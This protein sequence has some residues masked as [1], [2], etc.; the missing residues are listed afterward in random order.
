MLRQEPT[1]AETVAR[2]AGGL[3]LIAVV[4]GFAVGGGDEDEDAS[5]ASSST[6]STSASATATPSYHYTPAPAPSSTPSAARTYPPP[7]DSAD[8]RPG[9]AAG[10]P[11]AVERVIDGD[12]FVMA[13]GER[14]RV[15]GIDSCEAGSRGGDSATVAAETLLDGKSVTLRQEGSADRDGFGRLLRY[16]QL[17][18]GRD[19]GSVMIVSSHTSVYEGGDASAGYM[20]DLRARDSGRA[21]G[22]S[23]TTS[24]RPAPPPAPAPRTTSAPTADAPSGGAYY[25]NCDAAEAAG[26]APMLRG[27]PGYRGPLDRDDD[28]IACEQ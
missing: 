13:G 19:F 24:S 14:V 1:G 22:G 3:F 28:G 8:G 10:D 4:A 15:L 12:T 9:A 11:G 21:C 5:A 25:R 7:S 2:W 17:E 6:S 20:A 26:A 27:Q 18:D 23:E 16:V